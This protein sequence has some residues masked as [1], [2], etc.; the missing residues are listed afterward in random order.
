M[1]WCLST[2]FHF[3]LYLKKK[4]HEY[5]SLSIKYSHCTNHKMMKTEN[6]VMVPFDNISLRTKEK[7]KT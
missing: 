1:L 3:E 5:Q 7:E 2:V 6:Y 4:T